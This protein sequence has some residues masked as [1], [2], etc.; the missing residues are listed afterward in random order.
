MHAVEPP[1]LKDRGTGP[2]TRGE[3]SKR[4]LTGKRILLVEDEYLIAN[5][6]AQFLGELGCRVTGPVPHLGQAMKLAAHEPLDGAVLD[7]RLH[8]ETS[9][10][11]AH[12]LQR[13]GVPFIVV[14][15]YRKLDLGLNLWRAPYLGKPFDRTH[16][17]G[18]AISIF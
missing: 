13:K 9:E 18:A 14:S 17:R 15:G 4:R 12:L 1:R 8:D 3:W 10:P 11:L 7:V 5:E 6:I 16:L 2:R